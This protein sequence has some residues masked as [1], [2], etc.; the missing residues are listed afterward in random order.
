MW[1]TLIIQTICSPFI[2][3]PTPSTRVRVRHATLL[4]N[5]NHKEI[6]RTSSECSGWP[7]SK[8]NSMSV[9]SQGR[10]PGNWGYISYQ[11]I[12]RYLWDVGISSRIP[13]QVWSDSNVL[14]P[15]RWLKDHTC[16]VAVPLGWRLKSRR[17]RGAQNQ[18]SANG[19][20]PWR[21]HSAH[22]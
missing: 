15:C 10:R 9:Q 13:I 19:L 11:I 20:L 2:Q 22:K 4:V 21:L 17:D 3:S 16:R 18:G 5:C 8:S 14:S 7:F 1:W 12:M 6:K